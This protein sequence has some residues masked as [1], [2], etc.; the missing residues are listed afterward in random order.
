[1]GQ[2]TGRRRRG[3]EGTTTTGTAVDIRLFSV[4]VETMW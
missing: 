4:W 3:R 1:M 2:L